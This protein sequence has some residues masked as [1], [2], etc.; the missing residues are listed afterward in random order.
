[1][2][3]EGLAHAATNM[4][5]CRYMHVKVMRKASLLSLLKIKL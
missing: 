2:L 5:I 1:M 3:A 4:H